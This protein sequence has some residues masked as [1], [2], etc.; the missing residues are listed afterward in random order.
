MVRSTH[1]CD[2]GYV[3]DTAS[4]HC[5]LPFS[6]NCTDRPKLQEPK[7]S[8]R[9]PR[10]NG[11]F[12]HLGFCDQYV[13]CQNGDASLVTCPMGLIFDDKNGI[14]EFPDVA[15]RP[16]CSPEEILRF[17]CP[18]TVSERLLPKEDDCRFFFRCLPNGHPRLAGCEQ[19]LVFNR[20]SLRC[21]L[22]KFVKGCENY[23]TPL[24][25]SQQEHSDL[26]HSSEVNPSKKKLNEIERKNKGT[27]NTSQPIIPHT[28]DITKENAANFANTAKIPAHI[29]H[30]EFSRPQTPKTKNEH[31]HKDTSERKEIEL[32][33]LNLLTEKK[34]RL[35]DLKYG[36]KEHNE[37][38]IK[39]L[40]SKVNDEQNYIAFQ[41]VSTVSS[42]EHFAKK[43]TSDTIYPSNDLDTTSLRMKGLTYGKHSKSESIELEEAVTSELL[44]DNSSGSLDST[45]S[46][47][48]QEGPVLDSRSGNHFSS[49]TPPA[50]LHLLNIFGKLEGV[51]TSK[52]L[53]DNPP[54]LFESVP[55]SNSHSGNSFSTR[56]PPAALHHLNLFRKRPGT[57]YQERTTGGSSMSSHRSTGETSGTIETGKRGEQKANNELISMKNK[58]DDRDEFKGD[59]LSRPLGVDVTIT[60]DNVLKGDAILGTI[61]V[62]K[63]NDMKETVKLK[64]GES[65]FNDELP[66][67][68]KQEFLVKGSIDNTPSI[69]NGAQTRVSKDDIPKRLTEL[70]KQDD[71]VKSELLQDGK[72]DLKDKLSVS[73]QE[74]EPINDSKD[75]IATQPIIL[76]LSTKSNEAFEIDDLKVELIDTSPATGNKIMSEAKNEVRITDNA[77]VKVINTSPAN[78][79]KIMNDAKNDEHVTEHVEDLTDDVKA[80]TMDTSSAIGNKI[81]NNAKNDEHAT[82]DVEDLTDHVKADVRDTSPTT[83]SKIMSDANHEEHIT[84]DVKDLTDDVK[85]KVMDTSSAMGSTIVSDAKNEEY[86]TDDEEVLSLTEKVESNKER[87]N[88]EGETSVKKG[89]S[90]N[91][92]GA[93]LDNHNE[94]SF[95]VEEKGLKADSEVTKSEVKVLAEDGQS[96]ENFNKNNLIAT[97]NK[98]DETAQEEELVK[99]FRVPSLP[100][101]TVKSETILIKYVDEIESRIAPIESVVSNKAENFNENS[102]G[103]F[104]LREQIE[105]EKDL[106]SEKNPEILAENLKNDP[107]GNIGN[108]PVNLTAKGD[109]LNSEQGMDLPEVEKANKKQ[110]DNLPNIWNETTHVPM[111]DILPE[112]RNINDTA[113]AK[114]NFD[115]EIAEIS[116]SEIESSD[117]FK[118]SDKPNFRKFKPKIDTKAFISSRRGGLFQD[119]KLDQPKSFGLPARVSEDLEVRHPSTVS[120]LNGRNK[121]TADDEKSTEEGSP[122][123]DETPVMAEQIDNKKDLGSD[124]KDEILSENSK[125]SPLEISN[126][127]HAII[128]TKSDILIE[129]ENSIPVIL[130]ENKNNNEPS[131]DKENAE[132]LPLKPGS[133]NT[134]FK[135]IDKPGLHKFQPKAD[136]KAFIASRR[137]GFLQN[138]ES[139][140]PGRFPPRNS[141]SSG[142]RRSSIA[143]TLNT[144]NRLKFNNEKSVE[145]VSTVLEEEPI[146]AGKLPQT[147]ETLPSTNKFDGLRF[148]LENRRRPFSSFKMPSRQ[149]TAN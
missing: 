105:K 123:S 74:E 75:H 80:E 116:P 71:S 87:I 140:Q 66:V 128:E 115:T 147:V 110:S 119:T 55:N 5:S 107:K 25:I 8:D 1:L 118:K 65:D 82:D 130:S 129:K 121:S 34:F 126:D 51:A 120:T 36:S 93:D 61:E 10:E 149:V 18:T 81:V 122:S 70:D 31:L 132:D 62:G 53:T 49:R 95:M 6:V 86:I 99:K 90:M 43:T 4:R 35:K 112:K 41:N 11:M 59:D 73:I 7:S 77:K 39:M 13:Y 88:D 141:G 139:N 58:P 12:R 91:A 114:E 137:G 104:S 146:I 94:M 50:A 109:V 54:D 30:E 63:Y 46:G 85:A 133:K 44:T 29:R 148:T 106:A 20:E 42:P 27:N 24:R 144:R 23:Y 98:T 9:C 17:K 56:T 60:K 136:I 108:V 138:K 100:E 28:T 143:I 89:I 84:D 19:G 125:I 37:E 33:T 131:V 103:E 79:S 78:G 135:G 21:D 111:S 124:R 101:M 76:K 45:S 96:K 142:D 97:H 102:L 57:Q 69:L 14:C 2:D 117:I 26:L 47:P 113:V 68:T 134:D 32:G 15:E 145:H 67:I 72:N 38:P 83:V 3:F 52:I 127:K 48:V 22:P 64:N 40:S 92:F 16:D